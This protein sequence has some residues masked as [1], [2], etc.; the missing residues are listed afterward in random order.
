MTTSPLCDLA[1]AYAL[2][3]LGPGEAQAFEAH[4]ATC[5]HCPEAVRELRELTALL[6]EAA[7]RAVPRPELRGRLL[8]RVREEKRLV[9]PLR[10]R[11][12]L[13]LAWAAAVAGLMFGGVQSV[14]LARLSWRVSALADSL[15][16]R[17]ARVVEL[18]RQRSAVLDAS[19]ALYRLSATADTIRRA[20]GPAGAQ[21]FWS[22]DRQRWLVHAFNLPPLP[23]GR[24]YQLWY[25]TV[26]AKIS[27]GLLDPDPEGHAVLVV[28]VPVPARAATLAAVSIEPAGGSAQP[29]GPIVLAGSVAGGR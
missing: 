8:A 26:E 22:R 16:Q 25:V 15:S 24:A 4:L 12:T 5:M 20:T 6:A 11:W 21:V 9:T 19:T 10:S 7:P 14:R 28:D 23:E 2:G 27:A 3:A 13:W 17:E 1:E 18:E 29:T